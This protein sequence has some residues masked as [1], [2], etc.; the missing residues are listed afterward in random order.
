MFAG[1][2][3]LIVTDGEIERERET[4]ESVKTTTAIQTLSQT[5]H[6]DCPHTERTVTFTQ[7]T[8]G[9]INDRYLRGHIENAKAF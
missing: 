8:R 2:L 3:P 6:R 1:H 5:T 9:K 7:A 4:Q